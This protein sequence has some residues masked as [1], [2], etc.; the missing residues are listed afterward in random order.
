M[1]KTAKSK[2]IKETLSLRRLGIDT[3]R[4]NVVYLHRHKI[5]PNTKL[6]HQKIKAIRFEPLKGQ[7]YESIKTH[8]SIF[9]EINFHIEKVCLGTNRRIFKNKGIFQL[10]I[11]TLLK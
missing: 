7:L 5:K 9:E 6:P 10:A 11:K 3:Y 2:A 8:A 1:V 4:E